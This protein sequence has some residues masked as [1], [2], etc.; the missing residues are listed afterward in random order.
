M[1][2]RS[3]AI[4]TVVMVTLT[5][6]FYANQ[7]EAQYVKDGLV[8]YWPLDKN[9]I[10]GTTIKDVSGNN[11]N[12]TINFPVKV[13]AGK[14]GDALEFDGVSDHYVATKLL[15]TD[16][17]HESLTMMAWVKPYKPHEAYGQLMGG[18]DGG[19]DRGFGYR[20][21]TWE[22]CVG[23][24]GDWQPGETIDVNEWQHTVAIYT[25]KDV[26]FYKNGKSSK[27]GKPADV[28][29]SVQP[30]LFGDDI[31]CGPNCAINGALDEI[32]LYGRALSDAEVQQNYKAQGMA[33][34]STGK[35]ALTWGEIK[36]SK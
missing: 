21:D 23:H 30:L 34:D 29:T 12:G 35:L 28:T 4:F 5:F 7:V 16:K 24:G 33:V 22:I 32:L 17:Q 26:I 19:W 31:P 13:V 15:I 3:F 18:D 11:N 6:V 9:S 14:V 36:F 8:G 2:N 27:F 20:L 25:P 1:F 10:E